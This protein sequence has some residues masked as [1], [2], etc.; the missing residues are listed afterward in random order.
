VFS[1]QTNVAPRSAWSEQALV[2]HALLKTGAAGPYAIDLMDGDQVFRS[3]HGI[4]TLRSAAAEAT[5]LLNPFEPINGEILDMMNGDATQQLRFT[6]LINFTRGR[7]L[8]CTIYPMVSLRERWSRGFV[9]LN[10]NPTDIIPDGSRSWEGIWSLP[11][12][13]GGIV[14]FVS[15]IF[16]GED[17]LFMICWNPVTKRKTL[18]E[19][20]LDEGAD[21][22]DDGTTSRIS[23]Q[24]WTRAISYKDFF[25]ETQF[26]SGTVMLKDVQGTVDVGVW[27]RVN[28][29]GEWKFWR[30]QRFEVQSSDC[31]T[32]QGF[33]GRD[34]DF[35]LG[36][37]PEE[38]QFRYV[39]FMVRWR[40]VASV[41]TLEVVYN[42]PRQ[43][44]HMEVEQKT[45]SNL[46][47]GTLAFC[48]Y[49]DFEYSQP[50]RWEEQTW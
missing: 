6:S 36:Q 3:R 27:Y 17:R 31:A 29:E 20:T 42:N 21:E 18:V 10:L 5:T 9:T 11:E 47:C 38:R 40:G 15:G 1:V 43:P 28:G 13:W 50:D 19:M 16:T 33:G 25:R 35:P 46:G 37:F 14:Q 44:D 4:Q 49:S 48:G 39:Q 34:V 30:K 45:V 7:R 32:L 41:E 23:C 22:F 26:V 24:L 12:R 8:C 2:K